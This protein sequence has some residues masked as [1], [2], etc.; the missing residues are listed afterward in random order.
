MRMMRLFFGCVTLCLIGGSAM[1]AP[2]PPNSVEYEE[3]CRVAVEKAEKENRLPKRLLSAISLT[4][5]GRWHAKRQEIIAWPW[6]VYAEGRGRYLPNKAA[7]IEEVKTLKAKGVKNIDVGCMQVNLHFHPKAF[8][9]LNAAFDPNRNTKYAAE[10]LASLRQRDRSWTK[11]IAYYHSKTKKFYIPY[12]RKVMKIWQEERRKDSEARR[13]EA[14]KT[15]RLSREK[16]KERLKEA[17]ARRFTQ[18]LKQKKPVV[19]G[20]S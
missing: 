19:D 1:A 9:N 3:T 12:R 8:E 2:F 11:A 4:E 10:L 6:T 18:S 5:T 17:S 13:A 20:A 15:Y 16:L 14:R 7:A